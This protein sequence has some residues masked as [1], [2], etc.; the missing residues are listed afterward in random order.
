[1]QANGLLVK[2]DQSTGSGGREM[3]FE[4]SATG[5]LSED[6]NSTAEEVAAAE[7][8]LAEAVSAT[9]EGPYGEQYFAVSNASLATIYDGGFSTIALKLSLTNFLASSSVS[10]IFEVKLSGAFIPNIEIIGGTSRSFKRSQAIDIEAAG[11]ATSC[12][13]RPLS[14]RGLN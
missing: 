2:G 6:A 7:E 1:M 13:G 5:I 9:N 10:E 12:T 14:N 4:W 11:S 3:T 8:A